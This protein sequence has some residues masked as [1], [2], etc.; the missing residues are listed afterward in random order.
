MNAAGAEPYRFT[1]EQFMLLWERKTLGEMTRIELFGGELVNLGEITGPQLWSGSRA[2][3]IL[4]LAGG[5]IG[6]VS[7]NNPL[8][9]DQH[10]TLIPDIALLRR[11]EQ[12][13]EVPSA[14]EALVIVEV[15][16]RPSPYRRA[17]KLPRYAAANIPE[18]W[19]FDLVSDRI[20]RHTEPQN[21]T[22]RRVAIAKRSQTIS[23][24]TLLTLVFDVA[25]IFG[26]P[27]PDSH[28]RMSEQGN[29]Q[30]A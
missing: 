14:A 16:A 13:N 1:T 12:S 18:A 10:T 30:P 27:T 2:S 7:I 26:A 21:G 4:H 19:F 5:D 6:I 22:Y 17:G 15:I 28:A 23:S 25:T 29:V 24:T 8:I 3:R 20:E 11:D 9:F